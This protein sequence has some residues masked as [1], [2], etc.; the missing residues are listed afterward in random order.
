MKP[1][2]Y[3]RLIGL[4]LH[5][6]HKGVSFCRW[7]VISKCLY[8][9]EDASYTIFA[10][11]PWIGGYVD[12]QLKIS[13]QTY[14]NQ[15]NFDLYAGP[16]L[17]GA[18]TLD[19]NCVWY[20]RIW[21]TSREDIVRHIEDFESDGQISDTIASV[22]GWPA[23][24]NE[25]FS[26]INHFQLPAGHHG[27]WADF[28]DLNQN[29]LYEPQLGEY[30]AINLRGI[31][32]IPEEI[33]LMVFND[34][35]LHTESEGAPLGVE[36][37]LTVFG[38]NCQDNAVLNNALFN[39]YKVINQNTAV[40]DSLYFGMW[41]DYDLGCSTDD[42]EGC[43]TSRNTEYAYNK[44]ARDGDVNG[45]CTS[46][47]TTYG[48]FPPIQSL[49]YLSHHMT[50]YIT[51]PRTFPFL[52][53]PWERY[54]LLKGVWRDGTPITEFRDGYNPGS[55]FPKTTYLY[56]GDPRDTTQ[57]SQYSFQSNQIDP[58]TVS[59]VYLGQM[60][61]FETVKLET[62]YLFNQDSTLD[63]IGQVGFMKYQIDSLLH[64]MSESILPCTPFLYCQDKKECVWPGDFNHNG[65][66]DHYD[67]LY[68]GVMKDQTGSPR[69][70]KINW[71]GHYADPW[72]MELPNGLNAKH[73]D[74]N[75][76]SIVNAED[77]ERNIHHYLFT[78]PYYQRQDLYPEGPEIVIQSHPMDEQGRIRNLK[79]ETGLSIPN[80]LGLA[81]E[82]DFDSTYFELRP[83]RTLS[84]PADS[85]IICFLDDDYNPQEVEAWETTVYGF[86]K[87]DHQ[88]IDI[89]LGYI[90][91]WSPF[92]L[93]PRNGIAYDDIPDSTIIRLK[94]LIA[95]DA[96]G[97]DLHI[98]SGPLVVYKQDIVGIQDP[99]S[100]PT[101]VYP[102][103]TTGTIQI[104]TATKSEAQIY[105]IQGQL[106]RQLTSSEVEQ[107]VDV[108]ALA[109][110]VYIFRILATGEAIRVVIQ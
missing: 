85:N 92:G 107:P 8:T 89:D 84:C 30:P 35:G 29:G 31:Y 21:S 25:Y 109:Q 57:W 19:S 33:M 77:L 7:M 44:F 42:Y 45:G 27:G 3:S 28:M 102:N 2:K 43:D 12:G 56:N 17:E 103:P 53:L 49:T 104:E 36:V 97:N 23:E 60:Q 51:A 24:G 105:S 66:A 58:S 16:L 86:V 18:V 88:A 83:G 91:D 69:D 9:R 40:I 10:S 90:L 76:N 75:G 94:N 15:T 61:P 99:V 98:G 108:S 4:V 87:T 26:T 78:N 95:I 32:H 63:H 34:Q 13:A 1:V 74:G 41:S 48:D 38:F 39:T 14:P 68:W 106:V 81:Y 82:I 47:L 50:S 59:S 52:Y 11:S 70:G 64:L 101:E 100:V 62:V 20:N 80:V 73:G 72:S 96:D 79:I 54:N 37:Q 110:G 93:Y 6:H 55:A 5:F 46:G 22:F 71:D 65:I 67:L